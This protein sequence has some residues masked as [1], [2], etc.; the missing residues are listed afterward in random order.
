M[1]IMQDDLC[2][3]YIL[4]TTVLSDSMRE[5]IHT[6]RC[7]FLCLQEQADQVAVSQM[8]LCKLAFSLVFT[9]YLSNAVVSGKSPF[10]FSG[11]N[12]PPRSLN[13]SVARRGLISDW[14]GRG[15]F[16]VL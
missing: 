13:I 14:T 8:R 9:A 3:P 12:R 7:D 5:S 6:L 11:G 15:F 4:S 1:G 16:V 2:N 10:S